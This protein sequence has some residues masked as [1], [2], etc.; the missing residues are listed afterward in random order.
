MTDAEHSTPTID[1][2]AP[3]DELERPFLGKCN[4]DGAGAAFNVMYDSNTL[5]RRDRYIEENLFQFDQLPYM[6]FSRYKTAAEISMGENGYIYIPKG[7]Q[8]N[9]NAHCR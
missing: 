8:G 7:C 1:F 9:E 3:C 2:G 4:F 6:N 5:E